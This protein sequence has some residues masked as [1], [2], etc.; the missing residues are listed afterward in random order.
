[1]HIKGLKSHYLC[2]LPQTGKTPEAMEEWVRDGIALA[3]KKE[4]RDVV[5]NHAKDEE[6]VAAAGYEVERQQSGVVNGEER[7]WSERVL[8]VK[9]FHHANQQERG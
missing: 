1:M 9:S 6:V 4:L 7:E 8:V 3:K 5:V 2:L